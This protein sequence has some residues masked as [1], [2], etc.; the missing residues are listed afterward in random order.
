MPKSRLII[1]IV[2]IFTQA[3]LGFPSAS[4]NSSAL[5]IIYAQAPEIRGALTDV[6][7]QGT[8]Q[9][10][11]VKTIIRSRINTNVSQI[12]L[13]SERNL[14][15]QLGIF[16]E[17]TVK[18][19]E[20]PSGPVLIIA[21]KENP[22]ISSVTID[23]S[24][25][26]TAPQ[27]QQALGRQLIEAGRLLN[28]Q[29]AEEAIVGIQQT[30][31]QAG[32][33]FI[34]DVTLDISPDELTA[35]Q[36][37]ESVSLIYTISEA[38]DIT[39]ILF[40][41]NTVLEQKDL[42]DAFLFLRDQKTFET[43]AYQETLQEV[44]NDYRS[45][46]YRGSGVD[47]AATTLEDGVL[48]VVLK[49]LKISALDTIAIGLSPNDFSLAVGDLFNYDILLEDIKRLSQGRDS[50]IGIDFLELSTGDVR[51]SFRSGPP[52]EAGEITAIEIE[53]NTVISD[54]ALKEVL[55]LTEGNNFTSAL[56]EED[57]SRIAQ[58]YT[59]AGYS[60]AN[61]PIFNYLD[62]TYIQRITELKIAGYE[63]IFAQEPHKSETFIVTRYLP[64]IGTVLN[65]NTLRRGLLNVVRGGALEVTGANPVPTEI[66][67]EVLIQVNVR[68]LPTGLF[69][70]GLTFETDSRL[71]AN[72]FNLQA[73][74]SDTNF[75]G[76]LHDFGG[77]ISAQT[78]DIGFLFGA[79]VSY[80]I[81]WIYLDE[82]DFR[83]V[84]TR[85]SA[86][87][88]SDLQTDQLLSGPNG[89]TICLDPSKR[90]SNDCET[91]QKVFIGQYTQRDTGATLGVG[92]EILP[93]TNLSFSAR[94][95]YTDYLLEPGTS[96]ELNANGELI[97][98]D[99]KVATTGTGCSLDRDAA[100]DFLPQ[101]GLNAFIGTGIT[102]DD[103][104]SLNFPKEGVSA[105]LNTGVGFG[106]DFRLNGQ[107]ANY[108]YTPVQ[109]GVRTYVQLADLFPELEDPNHVL[110][111]KLTAGHQF[112]VDYPINR[113]FNVGDSF[114]NDTTIRGYRNAD[115]N[116]S[117][118]YGVG[119]FEYR[120]DFGFDSFATQTIIAY[121]FADVG[122]ASSLPDFDAYQTPILAGTGLGLQLNLG[123]AG[124]A[125]PAI[126]VEYSFSETN[127]TGVFRFKVGPVF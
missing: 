12:N 120:Y 35:E 28:T 25:I 118:S 78:S 73:E 94:G 38:A 3:I 36:S 24:S 62:G 99:G 103:R 72:V 34:V 13:E 41:G 31:T 11:L 88:F 2:S 122:W 105:N 37:E 5:N 123:L 101:S 69:Q 82:F 14:V 96:C 22:R 42:D 7:V 60:I 61:V 74:Y 79:R 90:S 21:V 97:G 116:R 67:E 102:Y 127:P 89:V 119:T 125:L 39:E 91:N 71:S 59:D 55:Q 17:V 10:N 75:L 93:F 87:L 44:A 47:I 58:L 48:T 80:S 83:E 54:E 26:I 106:S 65:S 53:G 16:A 6:R 124:I 117:Q 70:P 81:P 113:Y 76:R 33:P 32:F 115:I 15:L 57:F 4:L 108:V 126:R 77:G 104:D 68:E 30:Y 8:D 19:E 23:G 112:G 92:R 98:P 43:L 95:Q 51:V 9:T 63:V 20:Q 56:A 29:R 100:L 86:S 46:G 40:E 85:F 66:P 18:L 45:L 49:E 52:G 50:D 110:A 114:N 1:L 64:E 121:G 27:W 111:F 107:Q 109:F 84:P